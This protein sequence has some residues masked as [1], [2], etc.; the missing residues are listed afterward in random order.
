M[1]CIKA[2]CLK[3]SRLVFVVCSIARFFIEKKRLLKLTKMSQKSVLI[4]FILATL[5]IVCTSALTCYDCDEKRAHVTGTV[6]GNC[7]N[8]VTMECPQAL[9]H[10][11][12]SIQ[13]SKSYLKLI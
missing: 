11:I 10:C 1:R 2:K 7:S 12:S 9:T 13:N 3:I 5:G 4:F 6:T 8:G